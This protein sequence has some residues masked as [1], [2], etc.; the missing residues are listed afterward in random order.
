MSLIDH[1]LWIDV[2]PSNG[3]LLASAGYDK[4][5]KIF[6]KRGSQIV[7]TFNRIH[8]G[9]H[10][11]LFNKLF[12]TSN[13]YIL[14]KIFCVRW[15]PL[16][17]MLVSASDDQTAVLLDFKTGKKFYTGKTYESKIFHH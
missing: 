4:N 7:R 14:D 8:T 5:V 12:L 16:G 6:D 2:C 13:C 17:D 11:D 15:S 1:T 3:N 10:F 9:I